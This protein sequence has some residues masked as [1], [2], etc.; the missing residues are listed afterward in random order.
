[1][2]VTEPLGAVVS[3]LN[4]LVAV[5]VFPALSQTSRPYTERW[6]RGA[7][8]WQRAQDYL[9]EGVA[10]RRANQQG[11]ISIYNRRVSVGA[12]HRGLN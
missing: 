11:Q 12:R 1:M 10:L 8:D 4:V 5:E 3:Y 7:W 2:Y 6:E 9:A